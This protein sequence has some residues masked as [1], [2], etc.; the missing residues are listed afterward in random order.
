MC[1]AVTDI[2]ESKRS[3]DVRIIRLLLCRY[4]IREQ[5]VRSACFVFPLV[6]GPECPVKDRADGAAE[7]KASS[8]AHTATTAR[9]ID[10]CVHGKHHAP[11]QQKGR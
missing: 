1:N 6:T 5:Y 7:E 3:V 11:Q 8:P 9:R 2:L 4:V 10:E